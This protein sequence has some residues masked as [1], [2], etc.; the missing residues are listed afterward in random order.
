AGS[1]R[2]VANRPESYDFVDIRRLPAEF[3]RGEFSFEIWIKPDASFNV[4]PVRRATLDQLGN[5]AS[6]GPEPYSDGRWVWAGNWVRDGLTRPRGIT[7]RDTHEGSFG[8]QLYG[9]GRVRWTFAD[10]DEQM[11]LGKVWAVQAWPASK[12]PSLLDGKWHRIVCVRR[13]RQPA[14]ARLE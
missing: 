12:A 7:M 2:F 9:G 13:W 1:L 11:P 3:G 5:W 10:G 14:G 8:V 4:G 6:E